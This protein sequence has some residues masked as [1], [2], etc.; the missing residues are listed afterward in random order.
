MEIKKKGIDLIVANRLIFAVATLLHCVDVMAKEKK[1]V[2]K[3]DIISAIEDVFGRD[4]MILFL[5]LKFNEEMKDGGLQ[6]YIESGWGGTPEDMCHLE[7]IWE[8]IQTEN[9]KFLS[10]YNELCGII[11][12]IDVTDDNICENCF[13]SGYLD[14]FLEDEEDN[15]CS[16][17]FGSGKSND[18]FH[19]DDLEDINYDYQNIEQFIVYD[20]EQKLKELYENSFK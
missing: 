6:G 10:K 20:I 19:V 16:Y 8:Y 17:C 15:T 18:D 7:T 13:G 14:D 11:S 1:L 3:S 9:L 5:I 2:H 12:R 4:V